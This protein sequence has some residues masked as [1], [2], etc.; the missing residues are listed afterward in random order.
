MYD[1]TVHVEDER[2][3]YNSFDSSRE[4]LSDDFVSYLEGHLEDRKLAESV[5][6]TIESDGKV[7]E[8]Q[9]EKAMDIFLA[10]KT[11]SL[12]KEKR[13]KRWESIRLVLIGCIFVLVGVAFADKLSSVIAAIVSTIGS[14]SIWEAS[15]IWIREIPDLRMKKALILILE[16]YKLVCK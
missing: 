16:N 8:K 10:E 2:D 9:L 13:I 1:I 14:F 5:T 7:D 15:N 11:K 3:L 4:T 6:L 12:N